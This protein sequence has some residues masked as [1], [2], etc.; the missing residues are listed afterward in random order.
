MKEAGVRTMKEIRVGRR[1]EILGTG[2]VFV[3]VDGREVGVIAHDGDLY[4]FENR[5]K[6]QGG[7]VCEGLVMGKVEAIVDDERRVRG[8]RFSKD[9]LH[10][11]CPWHG[12]EYDLRTGRCASDETISLN[13]YALVERDGNVFLALDDD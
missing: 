7:P 3:D 10:L 11:V 12:W 5:C 2:R 1:D 8:E 13:T 9:V 6:H 4:A